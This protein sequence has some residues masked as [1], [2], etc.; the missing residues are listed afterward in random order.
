MQNDHL[1]QQPGVGE[2]AGKVAA[3]TIQ[4]LRSP[5]AAAISTSETGPD[6]G[7]GEGDPRRPAGRRSHRG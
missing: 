1:V 7:A 6:V 4:T 2:L 5:A 3:A